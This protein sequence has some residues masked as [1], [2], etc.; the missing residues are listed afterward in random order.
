MFAALQPCIVV[1]QKFITDCSGE[2]SEFKSLLLNHFEFHANLLL[3]NFQGHRN[4][5]VT[6]YLS[7]HTFSDV[8][9]TILGQRPRPPRNGVEAP[10]HKDPKTTTPVNCNRYTDQLTSGSQQLQYSEAGRDPQ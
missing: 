6:P 3:P 9:K 2:N 1:E 5:K 7:L 4:V 10:R 8:S